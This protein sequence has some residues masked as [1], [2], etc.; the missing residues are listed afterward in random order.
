MGLA[1]LACLPAATAGLVAFAL[2]GPLGVGCG[3]DSGS[4]GGHG[5]HLIVDVDATKEPPQDQFDGGPDSPFAPVS[6]DGSYGVLG[7]ASPYA[8]CVACGCEGGTYCFGG[9]RG[10]PV[11]SGSCA[12]GPG[13][14]GGPAPG[15]APLPASCTSTPDCPCLIGA[16]TSLTC[17]AV[18]DTQPGLIV[19]C[20]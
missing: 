16:L 4:P 5:D 10:Y 13:S 15:C 8:A 11:P 2:T 9:G 17:Y 20:P 7:D 1:R 14:S 18:C 3:D 6:P 12:G 19:Y